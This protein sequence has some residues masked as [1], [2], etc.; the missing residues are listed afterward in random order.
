MDREKVIRKLKEAL[1]NAENEGEIFAEVRRPVLF[2]AL[3]L[4]KEQEKQKFFVD[5]S[6]KIT[7]LPV[8]VRCK[9]CRHWYFAD[10]RIPS[11]QEN[12]CGRNGVVVTPDWF[13]ADGE[14]KVKLE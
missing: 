3:A 11:E 8:V 6:G 4:L 1:E 12:V 13:C 2:D 9:D 10:N 7:P 14:K 5:E